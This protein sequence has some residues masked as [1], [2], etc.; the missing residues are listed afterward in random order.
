MPRRNRKKL[1]RELRRRAEAH[2]AQRR[3]QRVER[4][5]QAARIDAVVRRTLA[6]RRR[7]PSG[8]SPS[9]RRSLTE[10]MGLAHVNRQVQRRVQAVCT[11]L[12]RHMP[13]LA[14]TAQLP[15]LLLLARPDWVRDPEAFRAPSGSLKRKRDALALHLLARYRPPAFLLRALDIDPLA[16]ARVPVEDHW[17]VGLLAAVGQGTSLPSLVGTDLLPIPL[18][19]RMCHLFLTAKANTPPL[20]ALRSAQVAGFGG[21]PQLAQRLVQTRLGTLRGPDPLVGEPFWHPIIGWMARHGQRLQHLSIEELDAV[22][23]WIEARQRKALAAQRQL[24]MKGRSVDRIVAAAAQWRSREARSSRGAFPASGLLPLVE[25][26]LSVVEIRTEADLEAEGEA[27]HHCAFSYRRLI[28]KGKVALFS[29]RDHDR[30]VVTLEVAL[31][32]G[33]V[34]QAKQAFNRAATRNQRL[35]VARFA[36]LNRLE[37]EV[38]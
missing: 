29:M 28:R 35:A 5:R 31:G 32:A 20:V 10:L 23:A 30:R 1:H 26:E 16:V 12:G 33:R 13:V 4:Q 9:V 17:A 18:T 15:W 38:R 8:V 6:R 25:D 22:V 2:K 34:V 36:E 11:L 14:T 7:P 24:S 21:P 19:R 37:V 27:M 3:A